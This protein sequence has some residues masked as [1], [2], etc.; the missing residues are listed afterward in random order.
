[1]KKRALF[2]APLALVALTAA[3]CGSTGGNAKAAGSD[4]LTK[5]TL[6]AL[7][8]GQLAP[9]VLAEKKGIFEKHGIDLDISTS[10]LLRWC[11][12]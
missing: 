1:M 6:G 11:P 3:G 12:R 7:P 10:S 9:M 4:G 5:V 2:I 8:I